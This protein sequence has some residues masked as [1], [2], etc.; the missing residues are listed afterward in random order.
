MI[1]LVHYAWAAPASAVGLV[2]AVLALCLGARARS[3]NGVLEVAGGRLGR[4]MRPQA[5][6]LPFAAI[7]FGHVVLGHD[8]A[9]LASLR[10][11]EHAHVRQYERWGVLLFP[12]YLGSSAWQWARGRDAYRDNCFE[13]EA[14][15][16]AA[17]AAAGRTVAGTRARRRVQ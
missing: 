2:A 9:T 17:R 5:G 16:A 7:T 1:R 4:W 13:Q 12:L 11:H 3:V 15:A 8:G 14:F 6:P 10:E